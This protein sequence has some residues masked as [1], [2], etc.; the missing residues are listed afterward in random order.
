MWVV[1][2]D[3]GGLSNIFVIKCIIRIANSTLSPRPKCFSQIS[4]FSIK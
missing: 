4:M 1:F 3:V 2:F